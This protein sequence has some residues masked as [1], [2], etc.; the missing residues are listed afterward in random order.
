MA[1]RIISI[2]PRRRAAMVF[3]GG[4][5][6]VL[7]LIAGLAFTFV[8]IGHVEAWPLIPRIDMQIPGTAAAWRQTH[9]GILFNAVTLFAI[10]AVGKSVLLGD[11]AQ[12][13][14]VVCVLMT[15]WFNIAGFVTGTWFGVRGLA[16]GGGI[17]NATT[18]LFF[19]IA[20]VTAVVQAMLLVVG[21]F[22]GMRT[23]GLG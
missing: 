13:L 17:A 19:L 6:F 3:N 5:M 14:L 8:L 18:Y 7:G 11:R 12:I 20:V 15:G 22:R 16:M 2:T 4:L 23:I 1:N 21:A 9:I 10:A